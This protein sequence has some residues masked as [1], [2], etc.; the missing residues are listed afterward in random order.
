M[1][2][3][4]VPSLTPSGHLVTHRRPSMKRQIERCVI[5]VPKIERR[6]QS[7]VRT[8]DWSAVGDLN[9]ELELVSVELSHLTGRLAR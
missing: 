5:R 6:L 9:L 8:H 7:A 1:A 4:T 3:N 2:R